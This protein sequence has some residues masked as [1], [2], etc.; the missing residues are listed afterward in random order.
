MTVPVM[1]NIMSVQS[2]WRRGTQG[3]PWGHRPSGCCLPLRGVRD[4]PCHPAWARPE[5]SQQAVTAIACSSSPA[6]QG[7]ESPLEK[8]PL[9]LFGSCGPCLLLWPEW[10]SRV[11][12]LP[13]LAPAVGSSTWTTHV[14]Q[15]TPCANCFPLPNC[16]LQLWAGGGGCFSAPLT[17]ERI[18]APSTCVQGHTVL[19]ASPVS[20]TGTLCQTQQTRLAG[21]PHTLSWA[22]PHSPNLQMAPGPGVGAFRPAGGCR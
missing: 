15:A 10:P 8:A 17:D 13:S 16:P 12:H 3:Q 21:R 20:A 22:A 11:L 18:K 7:H 6:E 4:A 14:P 9:R 1:N 5:A 2:A 19:R